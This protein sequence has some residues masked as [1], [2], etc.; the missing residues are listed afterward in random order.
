MSGKVRALL[1]LSATLLL[2]AALGAVGSATLRQQREQRV[3]DLRRPPGFA[4]HMLRVIDPDP[5]Q[6]AIIEPLIRD[7]GLRNDAI[8][9]HAH[10]QLRAGVDSM[11]IE[12]RPHLDSA[13]LRRLEAL[14]LPDPFRRPPPRRGPPAR[15][16]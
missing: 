10:V 16:R 1:I 2:G 7:V 6:R 11:I 12:L 8:I 4:A 9:R 15:G 14:R 3:A 13:Q 5:A